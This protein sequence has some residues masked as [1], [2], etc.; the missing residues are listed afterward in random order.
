MRKTDA[1]KLSSQ[2]Q[3]HNRNQTI[4]LLEKGKSRYQIAGI[5]DF[6]YVM[7]CHW[8]RRYKKGDKSVLA[9]GRWG[10]EKP[11]CAIGLGHSR[12]AKCHRKINTHYWKAR[13]SGKML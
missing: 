11:K 12:D 3:Q 6:Q 10:L 1:R 4:R 7:I 5:L 2:I 8:I 9:I 13:M